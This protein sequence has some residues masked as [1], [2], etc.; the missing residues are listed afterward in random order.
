MPAGRWRIEPYPLTGERRNTLLV[1]GETGVF[2]ISAT[3][4]P[5]G[6]DDV[7]TVSRLGAKIQTLLP[8]YCGRVHSAICHPFSRVTPRVWHRAD[9]HGEWIGAWL[10]GGDSV[11]EWLQHFGT[12]HGLGPGDLA[13]FDAL[14][15]TELA[16]ARD[17]GGPQLAAA[18][19]ARRDRPIPVTVRSCELD[20]GSACPP[21]GGERR[22]DPFDLSRELSGDVRELPERAGDRA[23]RD[24]FQRLP[25]LGDGPIKALP[26]LLGPATR[27]GSGTQLVGELHVASARM[28]TVGEPELVG[29][30]Q[31]CRLLLGGVCDR[32]HAACEP[33]IGWR[34]DTVLK[35]IA[36]AP[37]GE[38]HLFD[39]DT[40]IAT[41]DSVPAAG[42]TA[43]MWSA[44]CRGAGVGPD[45]R[46]GSRASCPSAYAGEASDISVR[47]TSDRRTRHSRPTRTARSR[48]VLIQMRTVAGWIFSSALTCG[49]VSHGSSPAIGVLEIAS[50]IEC[51]DG[52][53]REIYQLGKSEHRRAHNGGILRRGTAASQMD[54]QSGKVIDGTARARHWRRSRTETRAEDRETEVRSDAPKGFAASLLVPADMLD[55][56]PADI[57]DVST[58]AT[59]LG[60]ARHELRRMAAGAEDASA[61][62]PEHRNPFLM[63]EAEAAVMRAPAKRR[64][65]PF[66]HTCGDHQADRVARVADKARWPGV[67][68]PRGAVCSPSSQ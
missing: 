65:Q 19:R 32:P 38:L 40:R 17:A 24:A 62:A 33:Q 46:M 8:G 55:G 51:G 13:R 45:A 25:E 7:V 14:S 27:T 61:A 6:W 1:L 41:H 49:T 9:D 28:R 52:L 63:P 68:V 16:Q 48:P 18:A 67:P 47:S 60:P 59:V 30:T 64:F 29:M 23:E 2:V 39:R 57:A 54:D 56:V 15:K 43:M 66:D 36:P 5:G 53:R 26:L 50:G 4:P 10:I 11:I 12:E 44:I 42:P 20:R 58:A 3:Y 37:V 21:A 34:L 22:V 35:R 31:C